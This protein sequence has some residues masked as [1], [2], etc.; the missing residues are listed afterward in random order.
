MVFDCVLK[1]ALD[2]TFPSRREEMRLSII[3]CG[4]GKRYDWGPTEKGDI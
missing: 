1:G 3:V 2:A 4:R